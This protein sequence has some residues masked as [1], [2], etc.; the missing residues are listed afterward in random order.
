MLT[1]ET[2]KRVSIDIDIITNESENNIRM[3]L[4]KL[5]KLDMFI[6]WEDNNRKHSHGVPVGHFKVFY[7]SVVDGNEEIGY[8]KLNVNAGEV[9]KDTWQACYTLAERNLKS[10]E[11]N[12]LQLGI[13]NFTN[14]T[15]ER[16]AIEEAI[17]AASKVAYPTTLINS[18]KNP[19]IE[20]F[21]NPSEIKE[22]LIED[23]IFTKI[24]KL[25]KTN[26]EALFYWYMSL[27]KG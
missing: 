16:F 4:D 2:P 3:I 22:W 20:R 9:L 5:I 10:E 26:A 25:K 19:K 7:E 27:K 24:N 12:H 1:T 8:R 17:T 11:Y 6:S 13:K 18:G 21:K 14:F 23:P 15:V